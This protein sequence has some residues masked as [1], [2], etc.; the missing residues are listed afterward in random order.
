MAIHRCLPRIAASAL[1]IL[2]PGAVAAGEIGVAT[3]Y[4]AHHDGHRTSTGAIFHQEGMTAASS[5]LPLGSKVRVTMRE[6]GDSVVVLI[7]D[8][9][10]GRALIDLSRGAA[11]QIGLY[12]RGRGLVSVAA[13]DEEPIEV[14][15]AS[16]DESFDSAG[17]APRHRHSTSHMHPSRRAL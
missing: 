3:W 6:T 11:K 4:G 2:L 5:H 8:R 9:M 17:P 7:N 13:T 12:A 16:E 14:A 10:G 1:V 15:E